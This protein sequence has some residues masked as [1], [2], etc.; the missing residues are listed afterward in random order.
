MLRSIAIACD[1]RPDRIALFGY[2]HVPWM[3]KKQRLIPTDAL[4]GPAERAEQ[5]A[6]AAQALI[7]AGYEPIGLDHFA[8]PTDPL[9]IAAR[10]GR[11]RRNFQ[12][13]TTDTAETLIGF[14]ASAISRTRF[15]YA[16][17]I[18]DPGGWGRAV[19]AGILPVARGHALTDDDRLRGFVI[20]RIM[21][22]GSVDL[23]AASARF[24]VPPAGGTRR[25][26][27][28]SPPRG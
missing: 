12:G 23:A 25:R 8:L 17:N 24:G 9:A 28:A 27:I 20:E 15:G 6:R 5:A 18:A 22:D 7:A 21:C 3:A 4:P 1:M 16:Q 2:A 26:W 11:L 14:G 13:Y 19:R 10:E